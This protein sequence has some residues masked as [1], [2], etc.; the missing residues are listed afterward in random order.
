MSVT[1]RRAERA[2]F[3][4]LFQLIIALAG[5]EEL[6]P[7][8][9][10]AQA[11]M[12]RDGWPDDGSRPRFEAWLAEVVEEGNVHAVGY[13]ITF[14]TYSSFLARPT[15]Y[16]EDL[17]ILPTHRRLKIGQTLLQTLVAEA[18]KRGCGRME[19]VVL[20][21]N[22]GAQEFYRRLGA[23][24]LTEWHSYRLLISQNDSPPDG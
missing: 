24:H 7:P 12:L 13:A 4:A 15:L 3:P 19:W 9:S 17:F 5:F 20:D 23:K 8:D 6:A 1:I 10:A 14:E 21:W 18:E 16:L 2:D 22:T 11:R